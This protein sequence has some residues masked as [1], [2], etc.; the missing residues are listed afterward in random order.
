MVAAGCLRY[1]CHRVDAL[2]LT[3]VCVSVC[4]TGA[5]E[6]SGAQ[7][8]STVSDLLREELA[9]V[10]GG[11]SSREFTEAYTQRTRQSLPHVTALA[12][13]LVRS[14]AAS[15]AVAAGMIAADTVTEGVT[16]AVRSE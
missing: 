15:A 3:A 5:V 10:F 11:K 16:L 14:G 9:T 12:Q 6:S 1:V 2:C 8:H 13:S 4:V 7:H